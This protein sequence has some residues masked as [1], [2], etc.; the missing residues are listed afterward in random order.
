MNTGS[1]QHEQRVHDTLGTVRTAG[2]VVRSSVAQ[3]TS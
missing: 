2:V 3:F 1:K